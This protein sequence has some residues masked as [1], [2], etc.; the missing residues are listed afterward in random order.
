MARRG[1]SVRG[2]TL[3]GLL[4]GEEMVLVDMRG[5]VVHRWTPPDPKWRTYHGE[6]LDDGHL[7]ALYITSGEGK[8]GG[9]GAI[10]EVD[11]DGALVW[12]HRN[13]WIHHDFVRRRN[14]NTVLLV[15]DRVSPE[16]GARILARRGVTHLR[17]LDP[18]KILGDVVREISPSGEIVWEWR[19][20][21]LLDPET[22]VVCPLHKFDEW[23]HAN[24]VAELPNG[25]FVVSFR[26]IDTIAIVDRAT[27]ALRWKW[28]R[29]VLG[30]QHDAT[31]L[32]SGNLL[33]FDNAW[34]QEGQLDASRI[35]EVDPA[36]GKI[37]WQYRASPMVS[38][39]SAP[40]G[41]AQ[42]LPDGHTLVT[43]GTSGRLF[44]VQKDGEI[45]W[46]YVTPTFTRF[47]GDE[48][49]PRIVKARRY[50]LDHPGLAR[51]TSSV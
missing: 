30:H 1:E 23:T 9:C 13:P 21:E 10:A 37:V 12:K 22:D 47:R 48:K 26:L 15:W 27:G 46:E 36:Q 39:I 24:S 51:L 44:E 41:G 4:G 11:W 8:P 16:R 43:E 49:S 3:Y 2:V 25:D 40:L 35:V 19:A 6:L 28:G 38:C 32:E 17:A 5:E 18:G 50:P 29:G 33:V 45:V 31:V 42:R 34:H 7:L 14:G 20:E